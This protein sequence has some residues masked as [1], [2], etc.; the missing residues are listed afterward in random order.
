MLALQQARDD[1][2][3][4]EQWRFDVYVGFLS[5]ANVVY[6]ACKRAKSDNNTADI[7]AVHSANEQFL[8][9]G[10]PAFLLAKSPET[11]QAL[12]DLVR[13]VRDLVESFES[14]WTEAGIAAL[15]NTHREAVKRLERRIRE[16][17]GIA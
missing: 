14:D 4:I 8:A 12:A 16:E 2:A 5:C 15:L 17:M 10:S 3:R 9:A 7:G 13:A 1:R 11:I 6:G